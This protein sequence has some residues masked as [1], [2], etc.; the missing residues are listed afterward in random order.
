MKDEGENDAEFD[1]LP[2]DLS[3]E[4]TKFYVTPQGMSRLNSDL[5]E[6]IKTESVAADKSAEKARKR[7]I[8]YLEQ[9]IRKSEVINPALQTGDQARFGARVCIKDE[10]GLQRTYQI[11]GLY[12][13]DSKQGK[14]SYLSPIAKALL[15]SRPGDV[16]IIKTPQSEEELEVISVDYRD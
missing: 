12:E 6:V 15:G 13:A 10:D 7:R 16:V 14:V 2:L 11:V 4:S 1:F 9:L 3:Q 5:A 8:Q